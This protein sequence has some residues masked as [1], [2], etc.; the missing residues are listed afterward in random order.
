MESDKVSKKPMYILIAVVV[1][2]LLFVAVYLAS[3]NGTSSA[4]VPVVAK[5]DNISVYYTLRL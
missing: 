5:G 2:A 3:G 4:A 1:V